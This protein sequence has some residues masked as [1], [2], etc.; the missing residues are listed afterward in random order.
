MRLFIFALVGGLTLWFWQFLSF[1]IVNLH[2]PAS[3]YT[4]MQDEILAALA[5]FEL[6]AGQYYL[7]QPSPEEV[8]SGGWDASRFEGKPWAMLHWEPSKDSD[9][10]M[11]IVRS[12]L[13]GILTAAL[14]YAVLRR[15]RAPSPLSGLATGVG[16][17]LIGYFF[18]PYSDFIWYQTPGI[19]AH[20][21]DA[22]VPWSLIGL[23][24]GRMVQREVG[25]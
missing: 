18:I 16:I 7:G 10:V 25:G 14:F 5:P 4:P 21:I 17:G 6:E 13:I 8:A 23:L 24:A 15:M 22:I 12:M 20:L 19:V 11:P 3:R 2:E 1:A 9:M